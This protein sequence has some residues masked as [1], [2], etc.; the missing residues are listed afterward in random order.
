MT[1]GRVWLVSKGSF[2]TRVSWLCIR[3]RSSPL[4]HPPLLLHNPVHRLRQYLCRFRRN[5]AN[6]VFGSV[7][8]VIDF[9]TGMDVISMSV[10]E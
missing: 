6:A 8:Q 7:G 9:T 3:N 10:L 5:R 4:D 1:L 2:A